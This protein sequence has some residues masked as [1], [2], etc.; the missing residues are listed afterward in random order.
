MKS[1][2][3]GIACE[4][5]EF[6]A[7]AAD[8]LVV[9]H[10]YPDGDAIGSLTAFGGIL[11]QLGKDSL[12][13]VDGTPPEKYSYLPGFDRIRDL[14]KVPLDRTFDTVAI[15]D[16]GS[17]E[18]IGL[19]QNGIAPKTRILNIDHHFTGAL[20]GDLNLVDVGAAATSEIL[21]RLCRAWNIELTPQI[22]YGLFTGIVTDTGRFRFANT[23][24]GSVEAC[25]SLIA[26]G[27][28]PGWVIE[29]VYYNLSLESTRALTAALS[30]LEMHFD[31]RVAV[32]GLGLESHTDDSEGFVDYAS[33]IRGVDLAAFYSEMEPGL[34]KVS[35][36]SKCSIDVSEIAGR[37]GGGG[38]LKAAGYRFRGDLASLRRRLLAEFRRAFEI[39]AG[40]DAA[41]GIAEL[42]WRPAAKI[43]S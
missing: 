40:A 28:D 20:Y 3:S 34:F 8:I 7:Q 1:D 39:T 32:I 23:T 14:K 22:A 42:P 38:H 9:T 29:S 6:L 15:L 19:G 35:L 17:I 26:A 18:R 4:I 10:F 37:M 11:E 27:V 36:R 41:S 33:S 24:A 21:F 5:R 12:L 2:F 31:D 30:N 13:A 43:G 25:A 16:A